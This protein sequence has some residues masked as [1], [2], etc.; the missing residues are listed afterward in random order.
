[1]SLPSPEHLRRI[2][3]RAWDR[4]LL[5][6]FAAAVVRPDGEQI[7][8]AF[9]R[10]DRSRNLPVRCETVYRAGSLSKL[11]NAAA[12]TMLAHAGRFDLDAPIRQYVPEFDCPAPAGSP[13]VTARMLLC[14]RAGV[15]RESPVGSYFDSGETTLAEA[16]ASLQRRPLL[17]PPGQRTRYSNIGPS[18]VGLAIERI[19]ARP[20][21]EQIAEAIF[22]PLGMETSAFSR[23][24]ELDLRQV[25]GTMR[26][27][28]HDGS[29][30]EIAAPRFELATRPSGNLYSSAGDLARFMHAL[31]HAPDAAGEGRLGPALLAE[32]CRDHGGEFG[33]GFRLA[34]HRGRPSAG[35]AG[36]IYGFT[37]SL[38]LLPDERCGV[39]VLTNEDLS[40]GPVAEIVNALLDELLGETP[41]FSRTPV[42]VHRRFC[43]WYES[44]SRWARLHD[45]AR[46]ACLL[47]AGQP[48]SVYRDRRGTLRARGRTAAPG[49]VALERGS[50]NAGPALNWRDERFERAQG[51][52]E[53][54]PGWEHLVGAYGPSFIPILVRSRLGRLYAMIENLHECRLAPLDD[55]TFRL[56]GGMYADETLHFER[57]RGEQAGAVV[58][59]GIR[60]ARCDPQGESP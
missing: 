28:G 30:E 54:P 42:A 22:D 29:F 21:G 2:A 56:C 9:G 40:T 7:V 32:M 3:S 52:P 60:L 19:A 38:V 48:L 27:A 12:A 10:V 18:V 17:D 1:M 36:A 37:S 5:A 24:S 26:V 14:H 31:L 44:A 59:S 47:L 49:P 20:F 39:A 43:G 46:T 53:L 16:V 13:A 25:A 8:E 23:S 6:G 4:A 50:D 51:V 58:L 15:Q 57:N 34:R 33:L 35:H 41:D 11:F 45:G 55:G